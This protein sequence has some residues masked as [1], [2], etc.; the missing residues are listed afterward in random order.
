MS[1]YDEQDRFAEFLKTYKDEEGAT[2]YW[3]QVQQMSLNAEVSLTV[4]FKDLVSFDNVFTVLLTE[5]PKKFLEMTNSALL[6]AL[7]AEDIEYVNS[8]VDSSIIKIRFI[9]YEDEHVPLRTIRSHHIGKLIH[10][11]GILMRASEVKPLLVKAV[12]LCR[13]CQTEIP[14]D[15]E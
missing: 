6:A 11:S 7:R 5:D 10:I 1:D 2:T 8:L 13:I 14:Q 4:D 3:R 12:F 15:Q 9:G